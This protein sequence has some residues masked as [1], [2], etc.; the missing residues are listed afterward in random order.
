MILWK[1]LVEI[2]SV[3]VSNLLFVFLRL[4]NGYHL[5]MFTYLE[6]TLQ[7]CVASEFIRDE[8]AKRLSVN[9][10]GF[11]VN[12][13]FQIRWLQTSFVALTIEYPRDVWS[14]DDIR[15][16]VENGDTRID[17]IVDSFEN[18]TQRYI[19]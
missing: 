19:V 14:L 2:S 17:L 9:V 13:T 5:R 3:E 6:M 11:D 16:Y 7:R 12:D 10:C 18:I 8:E 15:V 1:V 4:K